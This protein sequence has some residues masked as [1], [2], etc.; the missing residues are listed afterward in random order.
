MGSAE[1]RVGQGRR[2]REGLSVGVD[3][4][5]KTVRMLSEFSSRLLLVGFL[6][7]RRGAR[8]NPLEVHLPAILGRHTEECTPRPTA[9]PVP[10]ISWLSE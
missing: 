8:R 5:L 9:T 4:V 1:G 6:I 10:T 7:P 3:R 2:F